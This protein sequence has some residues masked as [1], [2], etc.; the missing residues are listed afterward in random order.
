VPLR[1][2]LRQH[3]VAKVEEEMAQSNAMAT[4]G[5]P[6]V[7]LEERITPKQREILFERLR[8]GDAL[9][10]ACMAAGVGRRGTV[11]DL[12]NRDPA[13]ADAY[14]SAREQGYL[15][16]ADEL[17]TVTLDTSM[18]SDHKRIL[19]DTIKWELSKMLPRVYGDRLDATLRIQ[20]GPADYTDAELVQIVQ[21]A[22]LRLAAS[23]ATDAVESK[24]DETT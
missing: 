3:S 10:E 7:P 2:R 11:Y 22:Q 14:A 24:D 20:Q 1:L 6:P 18:P 5:R 16:R 17:R 9:R 23:R 8:E 21:Q 12:I 13:F 19:V 4:I 15:S